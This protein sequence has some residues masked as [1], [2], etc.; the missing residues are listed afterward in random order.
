MIGPLLLAVPS[1]NPGCLAAGRSD[2]LGH[3]ALLAISSI[4]HHAITDIRTASN[5]EYGVGDCMVPLQFLRDEGVDAIVVGGIGARPLQ[6]SVE[7]GI[8]VYYSDRNAAQPVGTVAEE[9]I[10]RE[11]SIMHAD[12]TCQGYANCH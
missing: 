1:N 4:G 7:M 10:G 5:Q 8:D 3:C 11:F 9:M 6:R 12:E 2:H